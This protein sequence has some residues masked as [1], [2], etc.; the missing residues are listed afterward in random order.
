MLGFAGLFW[1]LVERS[2]AAAFAAASL[3]W[4]IVSVAAW[5]VRRKLRFAPRVVRETNGSAM[6]RRRSF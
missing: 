1:W 6:P 3:A 2:V 5:F 4:I